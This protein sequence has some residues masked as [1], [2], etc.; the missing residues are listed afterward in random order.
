[1]SHA[2]TTE[3]THS[4]PEDG[5]WVMPRRADDGDRDDGDRERNEQ[6][7]RHRGERLGRVGPERVHGAK[8]AHGERAV[9]HLEVHVVKD[10]GAGELPHDERRQEVRRELRLAV[11]PDRAPRGRPSTRGPASREASSSR[12]PRRSSPRGRPRRRRSRRAGGSGMRARCCGGSSA[13]A[14]PAPP[15]GAGLRAKSSLMTSSSGALS[16]VQVAHRQLRERVPD[17][18]R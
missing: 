18:A 15:R 2:P 8:Q 16:T 12:A 9:S 14:S 17:D 4:R 1:M 3:A 5:S 13:R 11:A 10:P 7:H 6:A